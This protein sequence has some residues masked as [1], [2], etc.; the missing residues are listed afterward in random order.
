MK[1]RTSKSGVTLTAENDGDSDA[2]MRMVKR[3]GTQNQPK[4]K[5][6]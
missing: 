2:L 4:K 6:P 5:V 1:V 3:L